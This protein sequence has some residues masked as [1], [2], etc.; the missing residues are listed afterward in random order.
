MT[1]NPQLTT[2]ELLLEKNRLEREIQAMDNKMERAT[3]YKRRLQYREKK[4]NL[5]T[6]LIKVKARI[7]A[8]T[9]NL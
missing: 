8:T 7:L 6:Q 1:T 5:N 2:D 3:G 4:L 9:A